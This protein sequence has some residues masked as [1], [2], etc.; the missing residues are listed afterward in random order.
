MQSRLMSLVET[1]SNITVGYGIAVLA[2]VV[3]FPLFG[4]HV[5]LGSNLGIAG[6]FTCISLIRGYALRR[7]FNTVGR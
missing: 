4:M 1:L 5:S 7:I 3:V 6:I 2:Q